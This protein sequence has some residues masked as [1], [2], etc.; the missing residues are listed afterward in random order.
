MRVF[1]LCSTDWINNLPIGFKEAGHEVKKS[2]TISR[3]KLIAQVDE[4]KPDLILSMGWTEDQSI[5]RRIITRE[6]TKAS[7]IPHVYWS[8]EDSAFTEEFSLPFIETVQPNFVFSICP[9]TVEYYKKM[10]IKAAYMNFGYNSSVHHRIIPQEEN[11]YSIA[12]VA[13]VYPGAIIGNEKYKRYDSIKNLIVPLLKENIRI[14]FW[15]SDWDVIA[16]LENCYIPKEW[17]HENIS[18]RDTNKIY[19]SSDIIIGL[20]NSDTEITKRTYEILA[21]GG[22]FLTSNTSRIRNLFKVGEQLVASSS[23]EETV[24]LVK[25]YLSHSEERIK[26]ASQGTA[27]VKGDSYKERAKYMIDILSREGILKI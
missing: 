14:D 11:K 20:Q 12:V 7:G 23:P 17:M 15:G 1:V 8:V 27:A 3:D 2:G 9:K 24:K 6:V 18:Y 16:E 22:F 13:N 5:E 26:I 4:F 21:S 25:Y 19:N 10:G